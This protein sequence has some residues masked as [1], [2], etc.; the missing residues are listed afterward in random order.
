V[1]VLRVAALSP[2]PD[3]TLVSFPPACKNSE[4]SRWWDKNNVGVIGPVATGAE[5]SIAALGVVILL[6]VEGGAGDGAKAM[7]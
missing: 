5:A 7:W 2:C 6:E 4:S 1:V 3:L